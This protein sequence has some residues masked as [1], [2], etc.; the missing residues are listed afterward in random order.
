MWFLGFTPLFV[1]EVTLSA[2]GTDTGGGF[3]CS[4]CLIELRG[5]RERVRL[6]LWALSFVESPGR[7]GNCGST[8]W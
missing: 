8:E 4:S 7:V 1:L 6:Q 2:W 5:A 3:C